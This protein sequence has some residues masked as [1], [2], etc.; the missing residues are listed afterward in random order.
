MKIIC[1]NSRKIAYVHALTEAKIISF[2]VSMRTTF[3]VV[4]ILIRN[5]KKK[6]KNTFFKPIQVH[7]NVGVIFCRLHIKNR[8][9]FIHSISQ[10]KMDVS[11]VHL[12][13]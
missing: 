8:D 10:A 3:C 5:L 7:V 1:H 12:T 11:D 2:Q 13:R 6:E 9:F 4:P